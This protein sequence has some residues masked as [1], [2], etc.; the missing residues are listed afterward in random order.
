MLADVERLAARTP[1]VLASYRDFD[2]GGDHEAFVRAVSGDQGTL[3][4]V[5]AS[6]SPGARA[7]S[8]RGAR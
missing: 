2:L 8:S 3:E 6:C 4:L 7:R 5:G 1:D